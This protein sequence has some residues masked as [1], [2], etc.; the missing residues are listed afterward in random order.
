MFFTPMLQAPNTCANDVIDHR[1]KGGTICH[2][3]SRLFPARQI[4]HQRLR[5]TMARKE[6]MGQTCNNPLSVETNSV[7]DWASTHS[8]YHEPMYTSGAFQM[9]YPRISLFQRRM[10][11]MCKAR[12]LQDTSYD[13]KD[14]AT[15]N[16]RQDGIHHRP[17]DRPATMRTCRAYED[18]RTRTWSHWN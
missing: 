7:P 17:S 4:N 18:T 9:P 5:G 1:V 3:H 11:D 2:N 14:H 16:I 6:R 15:L 10:K 13:F 12:Q 8:T